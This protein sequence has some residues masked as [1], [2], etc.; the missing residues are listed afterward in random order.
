MGNLSLHP[1]R[2]RLFGLL[3]SALCSLV[4]PQVSHLGSSL[5][6][7]NGSDEFPSSLLP[8]PHP[9]QLK[10][11]QSTLVLFFT[12]LHLSPTPPLKGKPLDLVESPYIPHIQGASQWRRVSKSQWVS[13]DS[14][15]SNVR[16]QPTRGPWECAQVSAGFTSA[17]SRSDSFSS[18]CP[19]RKE[20]N[21]ES[22]LSYNGLIT[23]CSII[24]LLSLPLNPLMDS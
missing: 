12:D 2:C 22:P 7:Q 24:H 19:A 13:A 18:W 14:Q 16:C 11:V 10:A 9:Q 23:F 5:T 6:A 4:L 15:N 8:K 3:K 21:H 1:A 17:P 20:G